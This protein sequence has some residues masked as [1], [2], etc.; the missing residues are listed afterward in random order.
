MVAVWEYFRVAGKVQR[1]LVICPRSAFEAW[2]NEPELIL[3]HSIK[4]HQFS[5]ESI[6]PDTELLY[7]NYE[8]L[9][10]SSRLLRLAKWMD[11]VPT[12]LVIDEAH[13]VKGGQVNKVE[14][15]PRTGRTCY[16]FSLNHVI[17]QSGHPTHPDA[18]LA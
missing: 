11:Q 12:M 1:L 14:G 10:N 2:E 15:M 13:R 5:E 6:P 16:Q 18:T 4:I 17:A 9:E 7:V 8:Q 3:E